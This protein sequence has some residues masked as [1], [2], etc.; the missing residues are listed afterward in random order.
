[1]K[2]WS[3]ISHW[4]MVLILVT[5]LVGCGGNDDDL[6]PSP[7]FDGA[8]HGIFT[9]DQA[10]VGTW[11]MEVVNGIASGS[12]E[13]AAG[14]T[15][16]NGT[17]VAGGVLDLEISLPDEST[18]QVGL[19]IG[20]AGSVVGDWSDSDGQAGDVTGAMETEIFDGNY[21]GVAFAEGQLAGSWTLEITN[22]GVTG[23]FDG[24]ASTASLAGYV[25]AAGKL[26]IGGVAGDGTITTVKGSVDE[27]Q[28]DA[29]WADTDGLTGEVRGS[30]VSGDFDGT[31]NGVTVL[32]GLSSFSMF[33]SNGEVSGSLT[34]EN[35]SSDI[36]GFVSA[37]G[38][39]VAFVLDN[40]SATTAS[41]EASIEDGSLNGS[42]TTA[43][44]E[45][46]SLVAAEE[47]S[48]F[49][50]SY[51]GIAIRGG[52]Q[53][54]AW[55]L[56]ISDGVASGSYRE[57]GESASLG[58]IVSP[59]GKLQFEIVFEDEVVTS[60][61]ASIANGA[62]SATWFN[63]DD[64]S[65]TAKGT[66]AHTT[67]D[68]IYEG[69]ASLG[70]QEIGSWTLT[71]ADGEID[72]E[73]KQEGET[74]PIR[75]FVTSAGELYAGIDFG[76]ELFVTIEGS[77]EDDALTG[78][79]SNSDDESGTISGGLEGTGGSG[80][81][82]G[83]AISAPGG[84][85]T[86][87]DGNAY[88]SVII[89]GTEWT[90]ENLKTAHYVNG[91]EIAHVTDYEGA[92]Q[93]L[94][95]G[96]WI[97]YEN[98]ESYNDVYGKLYNWYAVSDPRGLC[99]EG[100]HVASEDDVDG[101]TQFIYDFYDQDQDYIYGYVAGVLKEAGTSHWKAPNTG[102]A[103]G[104]ADNLTGFTALPG[105]WLL[106]KYFTKIGEEGWWWTSTE[107]DNGLAGVSFDMRYDSFAVGAPHWVKKS[108]LAC[109]CV[110]DTE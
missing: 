90:V 69:T 75:G 38:D 110:K 25:D 91:D 73:Y 97:Y 87:A 98:N 66:M 23:F 62:I 105:G 83:G 68:N 11:T 24:L 53:I 82:N 84:G 36:T 8:Y 109:R 93:E 95:S 72:G 96:A 34:V 28:L 86:D 22:G 48:T 99:A 45:S 30:A 42:W 58:G 31:Y 89:G 55:S 104:A 70:G 37:A 14:G 92:W 107:Y 94:T 1:M 15:I 65:G 35:E 19:T 54:G 80:G 74:S 102:T 17:V 32:E 4:A 81:S 40:A 79:W 46:G 26:F 100:W 2:N 20:S 9:M 6:V 101:L 76:D 41:I 108:G 106:G 64:E 49:D 16:F 77:I 51:H 56:N 59:Q 21:L 27:N 33:V 50:G 29:T 61:S 47:N 5:T 52:E 18:A 12:Y 88:T 85:M 44:G 10:Q 57:S 103:G 7:D 3:N 43:S 63:T 67:F 78:S 71:I 39:L 13:D 60:V